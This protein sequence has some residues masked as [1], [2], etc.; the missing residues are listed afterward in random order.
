MNKSVSQEEITH[1][2]SISM[3]QKNEIVKMDQK[4]QQNKIKYASHENISLFMFGSCFV[5]L[6]IS[7]IAKRPQLLET[8]VPFTAFIGLVFLGISIYKTCKEKEKRRKT[9]EISKETEK[10]FEQIDNLERYSEK[11]RKTR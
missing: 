2:S 3:P 10:L 7:L 6:V 1:S 11:G 9:E 8:V 5:V 4:E